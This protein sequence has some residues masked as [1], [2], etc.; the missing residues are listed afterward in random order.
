MQPIEFNKKCTCTSFQQSKPFQKFQFAKK[1]IAKIVLFCVWMIK[2]ITTIMKEVSS[3]C[4]FKKLSVF[5]YLQYNNFFRLMEILSE[6]FQRLY[7]R[8]NK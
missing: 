3:S 8:N 5:N 7:Q 4:L 6:L 1:P 2:K